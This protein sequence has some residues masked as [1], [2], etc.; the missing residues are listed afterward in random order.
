MVGHYQLT[1]WTGGLRS[2]GRLFFCALQR[3]RGASNGINQGA[4]RL[5]AENIW[6]SR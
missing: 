3:R 1:Q 2:S 5:L 6:T 4:K